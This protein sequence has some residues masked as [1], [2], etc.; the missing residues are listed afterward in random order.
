MCVAHRQEI[1]EL[2]Q[3]WE[4]EPQKQEKQEPQEEELEVTK[5]GEFMAAEKHTSGMNELVGKLKEANDKLEMLDALH[6]G[7]HEE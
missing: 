6:T 7:D 4:K 2:T 1:E 3:V 5:L